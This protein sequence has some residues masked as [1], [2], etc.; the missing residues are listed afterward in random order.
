M[1][2]SGSMPSSSQANI[3]PVR[4]NPLCTSSAMNTTSLA[5]HQARSADRKPGAGTMKPPSPWTGSMMIA[6]RLA[7]PICLSI[8]VS[9]R[10]AAS[11][12]LVAHSLSISPSR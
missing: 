7:A 2:R 6:A 9:A 8:T 4:A 10:W 1:I 12:P 11:S 3:A 5:V